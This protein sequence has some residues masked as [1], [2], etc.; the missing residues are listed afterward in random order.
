MHFASR[1]FTH[2]WT[3]LSSTRSLLPYA[4]L[5]LGLQELQRTEGVVEHRL[6]RVMTMGADSHGLGHP[7]HISATH[8]FIT[9]R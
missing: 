6:R 8:D 5:L 9:A 2:M 3:H 1:V 7:G 4:I